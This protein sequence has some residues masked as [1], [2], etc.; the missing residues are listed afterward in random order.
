MWEFGKECN[1]L[2]RNCPPFPDLLHRVL[3]L[4]LLCFLNLR[5]SAVFSLTRVG[6]GGA[7]RNRLRP[8][9]LPHPPPPHFPSQSA[10]NL[11]LHTL[12]RPPGRLLQV[13]EFGENEA[14]PRASHWEDLEGKISHLMG[15]L[16]KMATCVW[17]GEPSGERRTNWGSH[18]TRGEN[19][20]FL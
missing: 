7:G 12:R 8:D 19:S 16:V 13:Q 9:D 20:G 14:S 11:H 17:G 10:P 15:D 18:S 6:A 1:S 4:T 2:L 5:L 3:C